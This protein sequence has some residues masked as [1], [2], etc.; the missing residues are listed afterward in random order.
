MVGNMEILVL[1]KARGLVHTPWELWFCFILGYWCL[2]L[3]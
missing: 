2:C 1:Y 3:F